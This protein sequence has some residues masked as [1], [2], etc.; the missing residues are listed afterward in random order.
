MKWFRERRRIDEELAEEVRFHL[1]MRAGLNQDQGMTPEQARDHARRQ[2]G[3][4][5]LIAEDTRRMHVSEFMESLGEDLRYAA[6]G[7]LRNPAFAITAIVVLAIGIG[8]T[9]AVFSVV[10][11][12]LFR[13]LPYPHA[14][15][16]V[17]FGI[18][19]PLDTSEFFFSGPYFEWRRAQTPF[20]AMTT[21]SSITDCDLTDSNPA[22]LGCAPVE[23]TFLPTFG[24]QP[25]IG[26]NFT[27]REDV[28]NGPKVALISY[29]LWRTRFGGD[30]RVVGSVIHL[31]N[32][33]TTVIGVLPA[34][35]EMPRLNHVD[36]LI[37]QRLNHPVPGSPGHELRAFA[38]LKP[39][40]SIPQAYAELQPL[41]AQFLPGVP[42]PFRKE[43]SLR[44][45][46]VHDL[47]IEGA[48]LAS[49]LLL[50]AVISVL[51]IACANVANLM[52][53][54]SAHRRREM[55]VRTVLGAARARLVRQTL[56]ES[57]LLSM[58]GA[59]AG[60]GLAWGL[61]RLFIS[62]APAGI[63]RIEQAHLDL[64]VLLFA[65]AASCV[66][67][68][69]FGIAP[70]LDRPRSET[71]T[72]WR[73]IGAS[74]V[75]FRQTLVVLQVCASMI[76]LTAAT[77]LLRSLWNLEDVPL[78]LRGA[79]NI[80]SA[81]FVLGP[82]GYAQ[83]ARQIAFFEELESRLAQLP[84][85]TASALTDS[86][87]PSGRVRARPYTAMEAEGHPRFTEGVGGMITWRF[88]TPGYF[89][90]VGVPVVEG[91][92]FT[93]QDRDTNQNTVVLSASLARRL[94]PGENAV[95]RHLRFG[96]NE[97]WHT[98]VGIA[99]DV[100][101]NGLQSPAS[102]EYYL[103]RRHGK[104]PVY[105][106]QMPPTGWRGATAVIRTSGNPAM[107]ADV[108]RRTIAELEPT[109]PVDIRTMRDRVAQLATG[110]RFNATLLLIFAAIG[111]LLAAVGLYGVI[112][113]LV[114]QRKQ[115]IGVRMALGA[116]PRDIAAMVMSHA[117]RWT[118]LGTLLGIA[119]SL[120]AARLLRTMLF[121]IKSYDPM[122]IAC[123]VLLLIGVAGLAAWLP[124]RRASR[125]DPMIALRVD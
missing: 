35:F 48:R 29:G 16:L 96:A 58:V 34:D 63:L 61:L 19:A 64:R 52:L 42:A 77:L 85:V 59:I 39:G 8:A 124:S 45:R 89:A 101:N 74:R 28:Q 113:F 12:I 111:V 27:D 47:Q 57:V 46:S 94:F 69:L 122:T 7:F 112:A 81:S 5:T 54:R 30:A 115:E 105:Q 97:P 95:G 87:P 70:A 25:I 68:V 9:T 51:L 90:A 36:L 1:D 37:P 116:T 118:L 76:L 120:A 123:T 41:F 72:G 71:L 73:T 21:W 3:N 99:G 33:P 40:I 13:D 107:A 110:P 119:G 62:I 93:E 22:R 4:A 88:I 24:I 56:T 86:M 60:C 20:E 65:L 14:D 11:R 66:C 108:L 100:K 17:S 92:G 98:V 6:R 23:S 103:I 91:R 83:P 80:V 10:D 78:G 114:A 55:A 121:G 104:D 67:G 18:M 50:G 43:V 44:I 53:A 2:F 15:R 38:R 49:W 31:N 117:A 109:V 82:A 26:H 102:P 75:L 32:V 125:V 84:G 106:N 79:D